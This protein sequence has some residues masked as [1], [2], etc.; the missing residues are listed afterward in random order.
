MSLEKSQ[1]STAHTYRY[2]KN[3]KA[4]WSVSQDN[5]TPVIHEQI[6]R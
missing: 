6:V 2:H 4:Y 1:I 5:V 3:G